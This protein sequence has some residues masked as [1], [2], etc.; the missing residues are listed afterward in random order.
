MI[1]KLN[2][3][4]VAL[5]DFFSQPQNYTTDLGDK[6][7]CTGV[8][9][10]EQ[11]YFWVTAFVITASTGNNF[12]RKTS[13]LREKIIKTYPKYQLDMTTVSLRSSFKDIYF[14]VLEIFFH[15]NLDFSPRRYFFLEYFYF[16][17]EVLCVFFFNEIEFWYPKFFSQNLI[18]C[19]RIYVPKNSILILEILL[20]SR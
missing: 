20:F 7:T 6:R 4:K 15:Q 18:F 17:L 2:Y 3:T 12:Y 19:P 13:T 16:V 9:R 14:L 1:L 10:K 5:Q 11:N 8:E